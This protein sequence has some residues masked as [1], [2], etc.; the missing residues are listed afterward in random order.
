[1][2]HV[3]HETSCGRGGRRGTSLTWS[4]KPLICSGRKKGW[5]GVP[6]SGFCGR[7]ARNRAGRVR[8]IKGGKE[9]RG[10]KR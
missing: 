4:R 1:M 7:R 9:G 2:Q 6:H 5:P 8:R 10:G 3:L